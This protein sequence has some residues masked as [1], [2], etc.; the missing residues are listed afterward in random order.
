M[1][2]RNS[3]KGFVAAHW[4]WLVAAFGVLALLAALVYAVIACGEDPQE[5]AAEALSELDGRKGGKTG[6]EAVDMAPYAA[7]AKALKDPARVIVPAETKES[8]LASGRRVFCEQGDPAAEAKACGQ[9]I[10]FGLKVCPFCGAKQ[11]EEVKVVLDSDGDGLPDEFEKAHGLNPNDPADADA[12]KDGDGFTNMEEF[13]AKTDLDD[14]A[15][16]PPYLDSLKLV[17]PLK[18]TLLPFYLERITPIPS[19]QRFFFKLLKAKADWGK[20]STS[21]SVL[22][23]EEIGKSGFSVKAFEKSSKKVKIAGSNQE[24]EVDTSTVTLVRK[25]DGK[26]IV[27]M[28]GD[29]RK[30]VDIQAKLVYERG[31]TKEFTVV[32]GDTIDLN[33]T[34]F[35][36]TEIK[37]DAKGAK[38]LVENET[39]KKTLEALEQ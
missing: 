4:D 22:K 32:P 1:I 29:K 31:E 37:R 6:V 9:P 10:P 30:P 27:L 13:L 24:K 35:K 12:D 25:S 11:P 19:G 5:A 8:F 23:D 34:K 3:E 21:L 36:V 16:H 28:M 20:G 38:V 14:P 33:G 26:T 2:S 7:A 18:E 17:T 39:T 15:S